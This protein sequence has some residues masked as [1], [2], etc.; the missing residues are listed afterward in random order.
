MLQLFINYRRDDTAAIAGRIYEYLERAFGAQHLFKD[1]DNMTPG[2]DFRQTITAAIDKSDVMLVLIG[3][4]WLTITDSHGVPRLDNPADY[5]RMEIEQGLNSPHVTVIP[6]LVMGAEMP[7]QPRLPT[8]IQDLAYLHAVNVRL[9]P[10]FRP[11][12]QRLIKFLTEHSDSLR[13]PTGNSTTIGTKNAPLIQRLLGAFAQGNATPP[14]PTPKPDP[15]PPPAAKASPPVNAPPKTPPHGQLWRDDAYEPT[16]PRLALAPSQLERLIVMALQSIYGV[17]VFGAL[18]GALVLLL[19]AAALG[20]FSSDSSN[21]NGT[22]TRNEDWTPEIRTFEGV[23]MARV[24]AGCFMMGTNDAEPRFATP[25]HEQCFDDEFWVDVY[26]VSWRQYCTIVECEAE[27]EGA[28]SLPS[29]TPAQLRWS[30]AHQ[31]CLRRGGR[32]PTEAEWEY[33]ARG[34][35]G[36]NYPWG[37]AWVSANAHWDGT[38]AQYG[39]FAPVGSYPAGASWVGAQDMVGNAFE[40]TGT[41]YRSYPAENSNPDSESDEADMVAEVQY[42]VRSHTVAFARS[43]DLRSIWRSRGDD[44][45]SIRFGFR[46]VRDEV[47]PPDDALAQTEEPREDA[48][49]TDNEHSAE[50]VELESESS[51]SDAESEAP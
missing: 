37:N 33:V 50:V 7:P 35:S 25:A 8:A 42:A 19:I 22:L 47:P 18:G 32:L 36:W 49:T 51:A 13:A 40:W 20:A 34:P 41:V 38:E 11:D 45:W 2:K 12:M 48:S 46:C 5:V 15:T 9:D 27:E 10:D 31:Y 17:V 44:V 6:V 16:S 24:P 21:D 29:L 14:P 30:E 26:E 3:P 23:E 1:V 43:D 39:E 28:S 4:A